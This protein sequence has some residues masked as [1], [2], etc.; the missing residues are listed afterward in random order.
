VYAQVDDIDA[1]FDWLERAR[2]S[3]VWELSP[4][5]IFYSSLHDDARWD[6]LMERVGMSQA[7]L[8]AIEFEVKL[9]N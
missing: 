8:D 1:A 7:A 9:P 3:G 6:V 4:N 2:E 5:D